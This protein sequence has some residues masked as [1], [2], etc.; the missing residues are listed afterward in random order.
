MHLSR[1]KYKKRNRT[2]RQRGGVS[3]NIKQ[4]LINIPLSNNTTNI[5]K[6]KKIMKKYIASPWDAMDKHIMN[7]SEYSRYVNN[8]KKLTGTG[9]D[10]KRICQSKINASNERYPYQMRICQSHSGNLFEHS[11]WSALQIIKWFNDKDPI[12]DGVDMKTAIVAAFFHDIGKGGDCIQT[13]KEGVC[14]LDMYAD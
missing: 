10:I 1:R 9:F 13:C 11:Q 12:I 7:T 14:W 4:L 8:Y 3:N 6:I 5:G 2:R